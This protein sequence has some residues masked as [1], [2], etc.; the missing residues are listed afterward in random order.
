MHK[1]LSLGYTRTETEDCKKNFFF[2]SQKWGVMH[3]GVIHQGAIHQALQYVTIHVNPLHTSETRSRYIFP[4]LNV[5][6]S[7]K[8]STELIFLPSDGCGKYFYDYSSYPN[9]T[10]RHRVFRLGSKLLNGFNDSD[11]LLSS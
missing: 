11:D 5:Q 2:G 4:V 7:Y 9:C 3:Q 6:Y 10:R 8:T 1:T